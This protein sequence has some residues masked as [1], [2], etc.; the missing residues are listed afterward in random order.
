MRNS[1]LLS[2]ILALTSV[3]AGCGDGDATPDGGPVPTPDAGEQ[4]TDSGAGT[5]V[6]AFVP[7]DAYVPIDAP[8]DAGAVGSASVAWL[9]EVE[10]RTI[11]GDIGLDF[12]L[13]YELMI[14]G[15]PFVYGL[16]IETCVAIAGREESCYS[17]SLSNLPG[18]S[19]IRW[20]FDP[21]MYA[22]GENHYRFRL[23]LD[24]AGDVVDEALLDMQV[25]VTSCNM[26]V[27][28]TP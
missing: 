12:Y 20:G 14:D 13:Q 11:D 19:G 25:D 9:T 6:D 27:G 24:R 10:P 26:C 8:A 4:P 16:T 3:F 17:Q 1:V 21:S 2:A 7:T 15:D 18:M 23:T 5:P 22:V 28:T